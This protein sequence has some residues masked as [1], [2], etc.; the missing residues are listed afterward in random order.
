MTPAAFRS[1]F[2]EFS[3][4]STYPEPTVQLWIGLAGKMLNAE[5]W[6]EL[7][8]QGTGLYVAHHLAIGVRDQQA[9]EVGGVP[10]A[11]TGPQTSK[12]VDKVSVSYD[13]SS[14][15][16]AD[17]GF[18]NMTSYGIRLLQLARYVGAGG[19]QL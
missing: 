18:W 6:D 17:G 7:I 19:V 5:R 10:G 12:S 4:T 13:A 14:V 9:A 8:D 1:V 11:V 3:C 15:T 16:L 2:P